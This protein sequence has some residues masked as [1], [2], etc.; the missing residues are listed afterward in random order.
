MNTVGSFAI[1]IG[2]GI[3]LLG[4]VI[5]Y[6]GLA[7]PIQLGNNA[8]ILL[9]AGPALLCAGLYA[10][11]KNLE[12]TLWLGERIGVLYQ[13]LAILVLNTFVVFFCLDLGIRVVNRARYSLWP[14]PAPEIQDE[15]ASSSY[16]RDKAWADQ[17]WRE[18]LLSR[19]TRFHDHVLWRRASLK[20]ETI[21]VDEQ[22]IRLTPGAD[23]RSGSF[24]VFVFGGSAMW[25]TGSPDWATIPAFLQKRIQSLKSG[26]VC[27]VN[28]GESGYVS[29]QSVI[30]LMVQLQSGNIPTLALFFDG[31]NDVYTAYQSGRPGILENSDH[32]AARFEKR[33]IVNKSPVV[34]LL[35]GSSLYPLAIGLVA[36]LRQEVPRAPKLI[37]YESMN[38]DAERLS[39]SVLQTYLNNYKI[40]DG[41]AK[42]FGFKSF[43]YWPA[44]IGSGRKTLTAEEEILKRKVDPALAKLYQLVDQKIQPQVA[45]YRNLTY[46]GRIFDEYKSLLWLDDTHVTPVGNEIIAEKMLEIIR[47]RNG[48]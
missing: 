4:V 32:L 14:T 2:G 40:V 36:K 37:T 18:F 6:L 30:E 43:F 31:V 45:E 35:E 34:E 11:A 25:G 38:I 5:R 42:E 29:T 27:L 1:L 20:G 47:A 3:M 24:K 33:E 46:L 19:K 16:Y 28:F 26:P 10:R 48:L 21:N 17:Y 8:N 22:G 13:G 7:S 44:Y 39:S 23:C 15:R 9:L 12:N 41:L